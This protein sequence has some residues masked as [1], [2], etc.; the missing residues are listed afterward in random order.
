MI[1]NPYAFFWATVLF[2]VCAAHTS[3]AQTPVVEIND[4]Y[5]SWIQNDENH[6]GEPLSYLNDLSGAKYDS[7]I[8]LLTHDTRDSVLEV[9]WR[10]LL[11]TSHLTTLVDDAPT[12]DALLS[13]LLLYMHDE[14]NRIVHYASEILEDFKPAV[15]GKEHRQELVVL[16]DSV[17]NP[18]ILTSLYQ[19]CGQHRV[20]QCIPVLKDVVSSDN[21]P[22]MQRWVALAALSR[23]GHDEAGAA[24]TRY[25]TRMDLSLN[26]IDILYPWVMFS[27]NR[28]NIDFLVDKIRHDESGCES[29]NP[30][31]STD[32]P[33]AY[34][35]LRVVAPHV[36]E[37][38][39]KGENG[40]QNMQHEAALARA[41]EILKSTDK[42]YTLTSE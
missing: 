16:L 6:D 15:Y 8:N 36:K 33:C 20:E 12:S 4:F 7:L 32:I 24:M 37:L 14:D 42:N 10:G 17:E 23:L 22:F 21:T 41:R 26:T 9:R 19:L 28:D 11:L 31:V 29:T 3:E 2:I 18:N 27:Q 25:L 38:P 34:M 30:N 5:V 13:L 1:L 35:L 39:W 40:L